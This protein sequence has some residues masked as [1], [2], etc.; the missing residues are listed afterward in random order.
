MGCDGFS[1][2]GC[3]GGI[4]DV[5]VGWRCGVAWQGWGVTR[6]LTSNSTPNPDPD[7][8]PDPNTGPNRTPP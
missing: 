8:D 1:L 6:I 4:V 3:G 5:V 2:V 7:P